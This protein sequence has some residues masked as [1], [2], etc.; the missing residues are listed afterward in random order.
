MI[1][2]KILLFDG[3][4]FDN[5]RFKMVETKTKE[6][7]K[8]DKQADWIIDYVFN[9]CQKYTFT[10][11]HGQIYEHYNDTIEWSLASNSTLT[12]QGKLLRKANKE[13]PAQKLE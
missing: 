9:D 2:N 5:K 6:L 13:A 11:S 4:I 8:T 3:L 12:I 1:D 10:N 7:L